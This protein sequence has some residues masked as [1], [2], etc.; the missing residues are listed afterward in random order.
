MVLLARGDPLLCAG[1][2]E[3]LQEGP[4][5]RCPDHVVVHPLAVQ[6]EH[7][8]AL[9]VGQAVELRH[10]LGVGR[11][12]LAPVA[13]GYLFFHLSCSP[14]YLLCQADARAAACTPAR[15]LS[16]SI[17]REANVPR[18]SSRNLVATRQL[19]PSPP[20]TWIFTEPSL[21]AVTTTT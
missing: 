9:A 16:G 20:S 17:S 2:Q 15:W 10:P 6:E 19:S 21:S 7:V 8:G 12:P 3:A 13:L 18:M 14:F 1:P 11:E 4:Q 5:G